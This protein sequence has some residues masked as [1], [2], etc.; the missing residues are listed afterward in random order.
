MVL[1]NVIDF[2]TTGLDKKDTNY[3]KDLP[4]SIGTLVAEFKD[5]KTIECKGSLY[6]LIRIPNPLWSNDNVG[7]FKHY[8]TVEEIAD[9]PEP[10]KVCADYNK[11]KKQHGFERAAAWYYEFDKKH[12]GRLYDMAKA[13]V[14]VLNWMELQ[15]APGTSLDSCIPY[16]KDGY[17]RGLSAHHALYDCAIE[18]CVYAEK[19]GY[20]LDISSLKNELEAWKN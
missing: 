3:R 13:K 15:P 10:S 14:P 9:A 16:L 2:E 5:D 4:I 1:V 20:D 8:L 11:F 6:S 12:L 18:L 17:A 7:K 19:N